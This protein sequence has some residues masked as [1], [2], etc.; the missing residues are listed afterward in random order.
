[1]NFILFSFVALSAICL[2]YGQNDGQN[3]TNKGCKMNKD[4]DTCLMHLFLLGDPTYKFPENK[5]E[6]QTHCR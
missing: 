4:A 1:M 2:A 3:K 6:M 5:V